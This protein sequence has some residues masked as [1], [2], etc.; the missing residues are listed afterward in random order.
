MRFLFLL[1]ALLALPSSAASQ[2]DS[3]RSS[4]YV[5][6]TLQSDVL[7]PQSDAAIGAPHYK[8]RVLHN[9]YLDLSL[10]SRYVDAGVSYEQLSH[11]L[12]G[13]EQGLR[14]SGLGQFYV[15]GKYRK[16]RL[17][18]G[19]I[20]DQFGSGFI[21]RSYADRSL[22]IDQQLR[23]ARLFLP[24]L[25][26]LSVKALAGRQ[27][28]Y[29][30]TNPAFVAGAE[31]E[32]GLRLG[33]HSDLTL[34]AAALRKDEDP[35]LDH[36]QLDSR[37]RLRLPATVWAGSLRAKLSVHNWQ[38]LAEYAGKGQDPS[39]DNGY[40][41]RP[42]HVAM[43]STT[44][45]RR[46]MSLLLQAKRSDNMGFRSRRS[47]TGTSSMLNHLPPFVREQ[48]YALQA[49]Y[50]YATHPNGEW[51][52]Q[53]EW[54][55]RLKRGTSWGGRY[56]TDLRIGLSHIQAIEQQPL[57]L[58]GYKVP[59]GSEGYSSRFFQ[60]G[61]ETYYQNLDFQVSR[62]LTRDFKLSLSYA[63]LFYNQRVIEG[64]G[65]EVKAQFFVADGSYKFSNRFVLRGE[66]QY[67]SVRG[68]KGDWCYALA[69]LSLARKWLISLSDMYNVG[70]TRQHYYLASLTYSHLSHR[71]QLSYGRTIEG[72]NCSGGVCRYTPASKGLRLSLLSNF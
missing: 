19:S 56:G 20:Y 52:Y 25:P 29:W 21:F 39:F 32:W 62:R 70:K 40:I 68:D 18:L 30:D 38:V 35:E 58:P 31:T 5:L 66:L 51:A 13:F 65:D 53:A 71:V 12:P 37:H 54:A 49:R 46:G 14:G 41:Y 4:L 8:E 59:T 24:L 16:L 1:A 17:T 22:G 36:I 69:E 63:R 43:L 15:E 57:S 28:H 42:G 48:T 27:R 2:S 55:Y 10:G 44:Y 64:K 45:S 47:V 23:G 26:N 67:A 3:T 6:G 72:Y 7:L 33:Q 50:P 34:G 60:W 9:S 61:D 11:P